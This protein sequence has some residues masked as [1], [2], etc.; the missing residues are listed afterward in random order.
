MMMQ[1]KLPESFFKEGFKTDPKALGL[2][3]DQ[4]IMA[5]KEK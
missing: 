2:E 1:V 3:N 4:T 5:A